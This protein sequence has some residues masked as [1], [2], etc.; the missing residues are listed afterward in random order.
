MLCNK[1]YNSLFM[2]KSQSIKTLNIYGHSFIVYA[3]LGSAQA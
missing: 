3:N 1:L 2:Y